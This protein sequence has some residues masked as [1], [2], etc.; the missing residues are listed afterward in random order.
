MEFADAATA[1]LAVST[2]NNAELNGRGVHVR[3][4]RVHTEVAGDTF[5]LFVGNIPWTMTNQEL[6]ELFQTFHPADCHI[7]TNM[8]GKSRGF[9]IVKFAAENDAAAAI[10]AMNRLEVKGRQI[11][12]S[13]CFLSDEFES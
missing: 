6:I 12:V 7:L 13:W 2:L 3:L 4:D 1:E 5:N 10:Q 8:Y 11:E 9:A